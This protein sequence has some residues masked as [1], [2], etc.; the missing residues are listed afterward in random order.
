MDDLPGVQFCIPGK[1]DIKSMG[2]A[3]QGTGYF[4][5]GPFIPG[6]KNRGK[7]R[8]ILLVQTERNLS[9]SFNTAGK[10]SARRP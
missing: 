9:L 5:F 10:G 1:D 4:L 6:P 7:V 2:P 3:F 8:S